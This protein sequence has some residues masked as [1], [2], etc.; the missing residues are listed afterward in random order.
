MSPLGGLVGAWCLGSEFSDFLELLQEEGFFI[1]IIILT[2][3]LIV[4][5]QQHDDL[6]VQLQHWS[7]LGLDA[8]IWACWV[9]LKSHIDHLMEDSN[10][11]ASVEYLDLQGGHELHVLLNTWNHPNCKDT[12]VEGN[13]HRDIINISFLRLIALLGVLVGVEIKEAL[14]MALREFGTVLQFVRK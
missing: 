12:G 9:L 3:N 2:R 7:I 14:N 13:N 1:C 11:L 4:E 10:G 8:I 5:L 6:L